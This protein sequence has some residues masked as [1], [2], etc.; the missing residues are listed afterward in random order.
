MTSGDEPDRTTLL[1]D[2]VI[3]RHPEVQHAL[4]S[5]ALGRS[6]EQDRDNILTGVP[7]PIISE[8]LLPSLIPLN[9]EES[10]LF[11]HIRPLQG[12]ALV[13]AAGITAEDVAPVAGPSRRKPKFTILPTS[14]SPGGH[15]YTQEPEYNLQSTSDTYEDI[16]LSQGLKWMAAVFPTASEEHLTLALQKHDNDLPTALAWMQTIMDMKDMRNTLSGAF[17]STR[18]EDVES[19][20]RMFKGDFYLAFCSLAESHAPQ[21]EW[22]NMIFAQR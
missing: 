1:P 10:L 12:D 6:V 15:Q 17:P 21:K 11:S 14:N 7:L 18:I 9:E 5:L 8:P 19:V 3:T 20:V 2:K 13:R 22:D 16:P 4:T